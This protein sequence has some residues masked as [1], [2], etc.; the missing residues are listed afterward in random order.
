MRALD[1]RRDFALENYSQAILLNWAKKLTRL[2]FWLSSVF[3]LVFFCFK[4]R[5]PV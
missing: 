1:S 4:K 2:F 3:L 5:P